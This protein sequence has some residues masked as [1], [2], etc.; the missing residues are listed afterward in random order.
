MCMQVSLVHATTRIVT[1]FPQNVRI[2]RDK[3]M[4]CF[5][6]HAEFAPCSLLPWQRCA[7]F[8]VSYQNYDY[9]ASGYY[10]D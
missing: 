2:I 3:D 4:H 10:Q 5:A 1:F 7:Y 6:W 8:T 9:N